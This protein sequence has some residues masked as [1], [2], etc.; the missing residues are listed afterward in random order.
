MSA[1]RYAEYVMNHCTQA[2]MSK[3]VYVHMQKQLA[4]RLE[5]NGAI[6]ILPF[7]CLLFPNG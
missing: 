5:K 1:A 3:Q 7:L 2:D 6:S 4:R